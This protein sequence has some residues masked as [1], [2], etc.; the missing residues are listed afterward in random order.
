MG[1]CTEGESDASPAV[2]GRPVSIAQCVSQLSLNTIPEM[3]NLW[4]KKLF[5]DS[6]FRR[7]WAMVISCCFDPMLRQYILVGKHG[8]ASCSPCGS[9]E[10]KRERGRV[11]VLY[12]GHA[13]VTWLLHTRQHFLN[14]LESKPSAHGLWGCLQ[15]QTVAAPCSPLPCSFLFPDFQ[16]YLHLLTSS[17]NAAIDSTVLLNRTRIAPFN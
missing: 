2:K 1:H 11:P 16:M 3:I 4:G 5:F 10:A 13:L 9:W 15:I 7:V 14:V 8:P 6:G 17:T 12:E